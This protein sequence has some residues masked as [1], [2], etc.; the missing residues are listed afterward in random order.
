MYPS[1]NGSGCDG[2]H[3]SVCPDTEANR[4]ALLFE[5]TES[6]PGLRQMII[7]SV[8]MTDPSWTDTVSVQNGSVIKK[9]NIIISRIPD[10]DSVF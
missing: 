5:K 4:S 3:V 10:P 1:K 2:I 9:D 6:V 7:L 8:Q